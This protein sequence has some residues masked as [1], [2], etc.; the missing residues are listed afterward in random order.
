MRGLG[1]AGGGGEGPPKVPPSAP[2]IWQALG[3]VGIRGGGAGGLGLESK[4]LSIR[5]F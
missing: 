4:D 1:D 5:L 2:G 3:P